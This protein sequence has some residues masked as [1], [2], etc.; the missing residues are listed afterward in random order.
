MTQRLPCVATLVAFAA[1]LLGPA[2]AAR[3]DGDTGTGGAQP[4]AP[5]SAPLTAGVLRGGAVDW[6]GSLPGAHAVRVE[7]LDPASGTWS[8]LARAVA[9]DD[10]SFDATWLGDA[11]GSYT[12]RA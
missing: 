11:L 1:A 4:T 12:V 2:A 3:A 5:P 6:K 7:R 10:G 9:A 8:P